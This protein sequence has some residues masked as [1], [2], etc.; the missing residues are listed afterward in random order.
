MEKRR[1]EGQASMQPKERKDAWRVVAVILQAMVVLLVCAIIGA[2]GFSHILWLLPASS[3]AFFLVD[4]LLL[5]RHC[6]E[7]KGNYKTLLVLISFF[8]LWVPLSVYSNASSFGLLPLSLLGQ[9]LVLLIILLVQRSLKQEEKKSG[10]EIFALVGIFVVFVITIFMQI[11]GVQYA[12]HVDCLLSLLPWIM[13]G[14]LRGRMLW[15]ASKVPGKTWLVRTLLMI[16]AIAL[17]GMVV[18][19]GSLAGNNLQLDARPAAA[20]SVIYEDTRACLQALGIPAAVLADLDD[21]ALLQLEGAVQVELRQTRDG[22]QAQEGDKLGQTSQHHFML[23]LTSA[24]ILME[25]GS[26]YRLHYFQ[27]EEGSITGQDAFFSETGWDEEGMLFVPA[28]LTG[29]L[30][31]E[32]GGQAFVAPIPDLSYHQG[33]G[34]VSHIED[35]A[36]AGVMGRVSFPPNATNQRGYVLFEGTP[37]GALESDAR[38]DP[39]RYAHMYGTMHYPMENRA[40]QLQKMFAFLE[41]PILF[42]WEEPVSPGDFRYSV[43]VD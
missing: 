25:D 29:A 14:L 6:K 24:Y 37:L 16:L 11:I 18:H 1:Q 13:V 21:E 31:Y 7:G 34:G 35:L 12:P 9:G 36:G 10:N 30:R 5:Y 40:T 43:L 3:T 32:L 2:W 26:F 4:A 20:S 41:M 38:L 28:V 8:A 27:V 42:L 19:F 15:R 39:F 23:L 22:Y 33:S 17:C